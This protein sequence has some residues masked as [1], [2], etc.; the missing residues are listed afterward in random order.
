MRVRGREGVRAGEGITCGQAERAGRLPSFLITV[1]NME[2]V[3]TVCQ[4][5]ARR[6]WALAG[7]RSWFCIRWGPG[8]LWGAS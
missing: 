7:T 4:V 3:L 5:Q 8:H 1:I 2:Q 6:R